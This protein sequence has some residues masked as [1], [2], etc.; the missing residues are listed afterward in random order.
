M[1]IS[2]LG[3]LSWIIFGALAGWIA[4]ILTGNNSRTG[5]FTNIIVGIIGAFI[6]GWLYSLITGKTLLIGWNWTAFI[7]AVLGAIIL[8]AILNLLFGRRA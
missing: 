4:S 5:C 3:W 8:L 1:V 7:V 2:N 6:G